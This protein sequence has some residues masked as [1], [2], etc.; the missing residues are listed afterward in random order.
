MKPITTS[1]ICGVALAGGVMAHPG[2]AAAEEAR[3]DGK[4]YFACHASAHKPK[5][6]DTHYLEVV[7]DGDSGFSHDV[8][9]ALFPTSGTVGRITRVGATPTEVRIYKIA[10]GGRTNLLE[11]HFGGREQG[12][13]YYRGFVSDMQLP[14]GATTLEK[15]SDSPST[16][17]MHRMFD[18]D[19]Q[20]ETAEKPEFYSVQDIAEDKVSRRHNLVCLATK[21]ADTFVEM[22]KQISAL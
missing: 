22:R 21:S 9:A 18:T 2:Q 8:P 4:T 1:L 13:I 16:Q 5:S 12:Q 10:S 11:L 14:A 7:V 17:A 20:R 6:S 3:L 15:P 19:E